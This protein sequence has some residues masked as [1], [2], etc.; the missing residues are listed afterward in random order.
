MCA[1]AANGQSLWP[2]K[3]EL[4]RQIEAKKRTEAEQKQREKE[5]RRKQLQLETR[6][7]Q[8]QQSQLADMVRS[9]GSRTDEHQRVGQLAMVGGQQLSDKGLLNDVA[10]RTYYKQFK[11]VV[12]ASDVLL[13]RF[14]KK[15]TA[16]RH[17]R[18]RREDHSLQKSLAVVAVASM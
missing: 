5:Q 4:L 17:V 13:V 15:C 6:Q 9:A 3:E 12:E 8:T 11:Q 16:T 7:R 1:A 10:R 14:R 2:F 18:D